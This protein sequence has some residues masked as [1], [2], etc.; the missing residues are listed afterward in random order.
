MERDLEQERA[1]SEQSHAFGREQIDLET[2]TAECVAKREEW[3][4]EEHRSRCLEDARIFAWLKG[5]AHLPVP[6]N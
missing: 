6:S 2:F 5:E 1:T 3:L 4:M